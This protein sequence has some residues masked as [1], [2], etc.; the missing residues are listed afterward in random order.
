MKGNGALDFEAT[1]DTKT[2]NAMCDEMARRIKGTTDT[3][4]RE[5]GRMDDAFQKASIAI[6]GY[7]SFSFA[8]KI[9]KEI[10]TVRGEF[11]QLEIAFETILK[12]KA[13]ADNLMM[14]ITRFAAVTPFDLK[15]VASGAKQLL[16]YGEQSEEV[17]N[18]MRKLGDVAS[19]LSIPFGDLVYLYGTTRTQGKMMTK[20]LM[21]FAGR[22]VPI[23]EELSKVLQVSKARV[24]EMA[25]ESKLQFSHLEQVITNLTSSTGMFG[26]M[27]E[28]QAKSL[29]G[30]ISNLGDAWDRMLNDMG[31]QTQDVTADAIRMTTSIVDNYQK[32]LDILKVIVATYGTYKASVILMSIAYQ[33]YGKALGMVI[34]KEKILSILQKSN[35]WGLALAGITAVVSALIL[36]NKESEKSVDLQQELSQKAEERTN[37]EKQA[38]E[39]L[40]GTLRNVNSTQNERA[41]AIKIINDRYGSYLKNMLT[42]KSNADQIAQA[43]NSINESLKDNIEITV[44]K[45]KAM[46]LSSEANDL[47][48]EWKRVKAMTPA[49]FN[50]ENGIVEGVRG[51]SRKA[52]IANLADEWATTTNQYNNLLTEIQTI[53][54]TKGKVVEEAITPTED[55]KVKT[56]EQKLS[57]IKKLYENYYKWIEHYGKESANIQFK[58][59]I[60]G[61]DSYL[62]YLNSQ[63]AK[64]EGKRRTSNESDNLLTL[65]S[66]K[67]EETGVKTRMETLQEETEKAKESYKNL[68]D[69]I[70]YLDQQIAEK[71]KSID[72]SEQTFK[73]LQFLQEQRITA[74]KDYI[75]ESEQTYSTLLEGSKDLAD[76]KLIIEK[77]YNETVKKLDKETL[78]DQYD[79]ALQLAKE[80]R[81]ADLQQ[82][83]EELIKQSEAYKKLS[84]DIDKLSRN[85]LKNY[86]KEL[87][88]QLLLLDKESDAYA[89]IEN[90]IK[91]AK[92]A[93]KSIDA[94]TFETISDGFGAI[95]NMV[96]QFNQQLSASLNLAGNLAGAVG[97]IASGN[98]AGGIISGATALFNYVSN[99]GERKKAE[100]EEADRIRMEM[101]NKYMDNLSNSLELQKNLLDDL[102]GSD[103]LQQYGEVF[104]TIGKNVDQ[105]TQKLRELKVTYEHTTGSGGRGN[106]IRHEIGNLEVSDV[107]LNLSGL[108]NTYDKIQKI[109][110]A[111]GTLKT[112]ITSIRTKIASGQITDNE[113][114]QLLLS[115]YQNYVDE[116]K[117][118][119]NDFFSEVTGTTYESVL[120]SLVSAFENGLSSAQFF[121]DG[122][123][124]MMRNALLQSLSVNA[125]QK[126]LQDWYG[127][128]AQLSEGGLTD[129]EIATLKASLEQIYKDAE[130]QAKLIESASGMS[131]SDADSIKN[132][133]KLSSAI[134]GVSEQTAGIIAGQMNA[135]RMNQA[136]AV[137]LMNRKLAVLNQIE[138]NTRFTK[139]I[140]ELLQNST[141]GSQLPSTRI[142]G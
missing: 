18:T 54:D 131:L 107:D 50:K 133:D 84:G 44:R 72:G 95:S 66:S 114:L 92:K 17:I 35:P 53:L 128:F 68:V 136:T 10:T 23:I 22:G 138:L 94:K 31:M 51:A 83:N 7:L 61:G 69:Y 104:V 112:D 134:K 63:I 103:K 34:A 77:E 65:L 24:L 101:L 29:P 67:D 52:E 11:Q 12:N 64:L 102:V 130:N 96:G 26:N 78:K 105:V 1:I 119:Q 106:G 62:A 111:I 74:E 37:T 28:K 120:D 38:L 108:T 87:E 41:N 91:N 137:Q 116:L 73:M 109:Q 2:F 127:T 100:D 71:Q 21:Q 25:S 13:K 132:A 110:T 19:G 39:K 49:Q 113:E 27:M 40:F 82:I 58:D 16:A 99:I 5:A 4:V 36:F 97:Q 76:R 57:E 142:N 43:Y 55:K 88:R 89:D 47:A 135:I 9:V 45:E 90:A 85:A 33:G 86:T 6:T 125:L 121:A 140:F 14:E 8:S 115:E 75:K 118:I 124:D 3:A 81:D 46:K 139:L 15:Q 123:E 141:S 32:V 98:V 126:P 129:E 48:E 60:K 93:I 56:F 59:L 117:A 79:E 30:L 20:D 70:T 80:K 42:E 122:F